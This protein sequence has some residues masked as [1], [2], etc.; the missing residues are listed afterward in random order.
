MINFGIRGDNGVYYITSS[1]FEILVHDGVSRRLDKPQFHNNC[2]ILGIMKIYAS[3][4]EYNIFIDSYDMICG[5]CELKERE[6]F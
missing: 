6:Q 3:E 4:E 5:M 1:F 2:I